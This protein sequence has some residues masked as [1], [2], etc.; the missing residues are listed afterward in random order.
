MADQFPV[1]QIFAMI[2]WQARKILKGG[3]SEE[4]II[5]DTRNRRIRIKPCNDGIQKGFR[6]G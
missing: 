2:I 1:H 6:R 3:S 4:E 5:P